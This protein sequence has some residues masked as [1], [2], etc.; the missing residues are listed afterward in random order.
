MRFRGS[1]AKS[2]TASDDSTSKPDVATIPSTPRRL[3]GNCPSS[4]D[5]GSGYTCLFTCPYMSM[6]TYLCT[7]PN[8]AAANLGKQARKSLAPML[9]LSCKWRVLKKL[10]AQFQCLPQEWPRGPWPMAC[11]P[12]RMACGVWPRMAY[13]LRPMA[14]WPMSDGLKSI[15]ACSHGL[16]PMAMVYG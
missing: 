16:W 4:S 2:T 15:M 14:K 7:C 12:W 8:A 11:G 9:P 3:T 10:V 13:C 5:L 6:H 1:A